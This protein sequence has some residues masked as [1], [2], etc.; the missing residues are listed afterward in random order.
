[1]SSL[2]PPFKTEHFGLN[3]QTRF[4][5]NHYFVTKTGAIELFDIYTVQCMFLQYYTNI[6]NNK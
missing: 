4:N 2:I 6:K 5:E 3:N 1:M